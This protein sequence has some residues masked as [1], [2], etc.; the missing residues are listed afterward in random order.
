[1]IVSFEYDERASFTEPSSTINLL[2]ILILHS[3]IARG[4]WVGNA[5][6]HVTVWCSWM[7]VWCLQGK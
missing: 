3:I 7:E 6:V 1:M 2:L 4:D 5:T